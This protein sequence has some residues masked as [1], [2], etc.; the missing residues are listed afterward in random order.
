MEI[1]PWIVEVVVEG[2]EAL[3]PEALNAPLRSLNPALLSSKL[4]LLAAA[5]A[6]GGEALLLELPGAA[7]CRRDPPHP[8][9]LLFEN[10]DTPEA[11]TSLAVEL[12]P[13]LHSANTLSVEPLE[14]GALVLWQH[15]EHGAPVDR[16]Q[17]LLGIGFV[18]T[19]LE[20]IGCEGLTLTSASS[21]GKGGEALFGDGRWHA[22]PAEV[23][24]CVVRWTGLG[25]RMPL[26]GLSTLLLQE[27]QLSP[28]KL[29]LPDQIRA[30]VR[31]DPDASWSLSRVASSLRMA[32]R[33]L[34]RR[35]AAEGESLSTLL[36]A[37]RLDCACEQ[38]QNSELSVTEIAAVTGFSDSSHL[39]RHLKSALGCTPTAYR[40]QHR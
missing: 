28:L 15:T 13:M 5:V 34:Q 24:G 27:V 31:A 35:L 36:W 2:L 14:P 9:W 26:R 11:L 20:A 32:P 7:R 40:K 21:A 29:P 39:R 16:L 8:L 19:L 3:A 10:V 4:A 37:S 38:L 25:R 22:A 12:Y 17:T 33:S 18:G 23:D 30:L 6:H 1:H